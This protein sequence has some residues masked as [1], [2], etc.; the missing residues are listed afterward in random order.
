MV[1]KGKRSGVADVDVVVFL[2]H[3]ICRPRRV[4]VAERRTD[5][6]TD[7][8]GG[9]IL[10]GPRH[11]RGCGQLETPNGNTGG[12]KDGVPSTPTKDRLGAK[13]AAA[14]VTESFFALGRGIARR[15]RALGR[16]AR[17]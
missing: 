8:R 13:E 5:G 10:A 11:V 16:R 9:E 14:G 7:G 1:G 15:T 17:P 6:R 12:G 3:R 2:S 4:W